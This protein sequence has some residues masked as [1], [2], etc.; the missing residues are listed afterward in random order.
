VGNVIEKYSLD[1]LRRKGLEISFKCPYCSSARLSMRSKEDMDFWG[2]V[3]CPKCNARV[4]LDSLT[5]VAMR[6]GEAPE[7]QG[8]GGEGRVQA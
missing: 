2:G 3:Q 1:R 7:G 6:D 4:V 5:L 8:G